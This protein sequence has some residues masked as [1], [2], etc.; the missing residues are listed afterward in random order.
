MFTSLP[1]E[2]ITL[3]CGDWLDVKAVGQLDA[4]YSNCRDRPSFLAALHNAPI[5]CHKVLKQKPPYPNDIT[6][7][8]TLFSF[9]NWFKSRVQWTSSA[10]SMSATIDLSHD[11][12]AIIQSLQ[13]SGIAPSQYNFVYGLNIDINFLTAGTDYGARFAWFLS[14]FPQ[15]KETYIQVP[16]F[17]V[18]PTTHLCQ[19]LTNNPQLERIYF[20]FVRDFESTCAQFEKT[21][22]SHCFKSIR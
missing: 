6:Y 22:Q 12:T 19:V 14:H 13:S 3:V 2:V 7:Y 16:K 15:A 9:C 21:R 11:H 4:A 1:T 17:E 8:T 10:K 18:E 20:D 5:S